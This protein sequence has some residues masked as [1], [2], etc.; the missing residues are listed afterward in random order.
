MKIILENVIP[1]VMLN[2]KNQTQDTTI[3]PL[4]MEKNLI[5]P[6]RFATSASNTR[7][8]CFLFLLFPNLAK[9]LFPVF[10]KRT[11]GD[12]QGAGFIKTCKTIGSGRILFKIIINNSLLIN[13]LFIFERTTT[14]KSNCQS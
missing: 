11:L 1:E 10:R 4:Y 14:E 12:R 8:A 3:F 5:N 2:Q 9:A 7:L 13:N 6:S